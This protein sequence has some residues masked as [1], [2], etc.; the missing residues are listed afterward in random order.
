MKKFFTITLLF[1]IL[2][3]CGFKTFNPKNEINFNINKI[4]MSGDKYLNYIIRNKLS[5]LNQNNISKKNYSLSLISSIDKIIKEKNIRN[6]IKKY[7][8]I[9]LVKV[10][11]QDDLNEI[12]ETYT[13]T[14]RQTYHVGDYHSQTKNRE[15][16]IIKL[17]SKNIADDIIKKIILFK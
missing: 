16:R 8:L 4:T 5:V 9:F 6:E 12:I 7:E 14:Q 11:L 10:N 13:F 2:N 15:K 1:I 17:T 3:N